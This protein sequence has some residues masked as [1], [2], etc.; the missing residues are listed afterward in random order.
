M[1]L[2]STSSSKT[3]EISKFQIARIASVDARGLSVAVPLDDV[4]RFV[5]SHVGDLVN[6]AK[7]NIAKVKECA[8]YH[9]VNA[10]ASIA[11]EHFL[12]RCL[13]KG[14]EDVCCQ[15]NPGAF[16]FSFPYIELFTSD[17]QP[18]QASE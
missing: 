7:Q 14:V 1:A 12:V 10:P 18:P 5:E 15:V 4:I 13:I 3:I 16:H 17:K 11:E 6:P 8:R 2:S 9:F